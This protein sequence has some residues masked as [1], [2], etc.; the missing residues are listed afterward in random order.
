MSEIIKEEKK[1]KVI[2][3]FAF[4][5]VI[6]IAGIVLSYIYNAQKKYVPPPPS[7]K[8]DLTGTKDIAK[9][10]WISQS[11]TQMQE[12]ERKIEELQKTITALKDLKSLQQPPVPP[13]PPPSSSIKEQQIVGG[14]PSGS[15]SAPNSNISHL[16]PPLPSSLQST[17]SVPHSSHGPQVKQ[18]A[19]VEK[20]LTNLIVVEEIK[21][22]SSSTDK[23]K[24]DKEDYKDTHD[25]EV[26]RNDSYIP[27]GSFVKV[28][29]LNGIDA[30]TG[31]KGKGSPY[32]VLMRILNFAQL[33]N[34]WRGD[35]KECFIVGEAVG[36]LSSERV[37]IRT[38]TL[39]CINKKGEVLEGSISGYVVGEDGKI[40]L[41]GRVVTKQGAIL[42]RSLIAGFLQGVSTAFSQSSNVL[43]ITPSG[44]I[45][46]VDPSKVAQAGI[47]MGVSKAT[48]DLA[49]FYID[50]AK[51]LFPV[52]EANAG[53]QVEVVL[54][55]KSSLNKLTK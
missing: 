45:T 38:N 15:S 13:L 31:S 49:K 36:E 9:E 10:S 23:T 28:V 47:G 41:S 37:H 22:V 24:N 48:E 29:L 25:K 27:S 51:E 7:P 52:I 54:V 46:T 5:V 14:T 12:H 18:D 8:V 44:N 55:S 6:L 30:P 43:N 35:I 19:R 34:Y 1:R 33:P 39:S 11:A 16:Y 26:P 42:A 3:I 50:L 20:Q 2:V 32:P 21:T 17:S 40:G 53:R 4:V